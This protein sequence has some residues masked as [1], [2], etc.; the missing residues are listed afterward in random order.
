M[1]QQ[2]RFMLALV[3]S[4]AVLIAWNYLFPPVK[5]PQNA[6]ANQAAQASPQSSA[7]GSPTALAQPSATA[8]ASPLP[9]Q[10]AAAPT[11]TPD[12]VPQ[13]KLRVVTPL[14]EATFDTRG[15]V[16]TSWIITRNKN[17][18][19]EIHAA[20]STKNDPKPLEMI[21]AVPA[22]VSPDQVFRSVER[23]AT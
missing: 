15:A 1:K 19:R 8:T 14:Y 11:P 16:A 6:N 3:F 17:T 21:S 2:Q 23:K 12:T 13:R 5:P 7:Q 10:A 20:N 18:G 4:A 22:G 9:A